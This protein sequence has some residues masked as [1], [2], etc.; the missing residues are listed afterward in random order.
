MQL[1]DHSSSAVHIS[2]GQA[3]ASV[4]DSAGAASPGGGRER[5]F[6]LRHFGAL[7]LELGL[8]REGVAKARLEARQPAGDFGDGAALL[9]KFDFEPA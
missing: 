7:F 8:M 3:A 9:G 1:N 6:E 4:G 2:I 5:G